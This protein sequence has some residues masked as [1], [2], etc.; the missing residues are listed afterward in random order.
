[1]LG[2][3][4]EKIGLWPAAAAAQAPLRENDPDRSIPARPP[5]D[6]LEEH[7]KKSR[8]EDAR[9]LLPQLAESMTRWLSRW[10]CSARA[11][12]LW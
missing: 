7:L 11:L 4:R 10:R 5:I 1:M 8:F 6:V 3:L 9:K 12:V 2:R